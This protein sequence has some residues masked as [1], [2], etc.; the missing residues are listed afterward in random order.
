MKKGEHISAF[1][2]P[3]SV[4]SC[5]AGVG[6]ADVHNRDPRDMPLVSGGAKV[7]VVGNGVLACAE[8]KGMNVVFCQLAPWQFDGPKPT[9]ANLRRTH[10][11]V[12]FLLSR[13]LA[14]LGVSG[15]TP[16]LTRF[17]TPVAAARA[18]KRWL[19]GLYLDTPEEW[20]EPYRFFRW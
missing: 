2:E 16:I 10:R 19:D 1:F 8:G 13:L 17:S 7:R 5:L 11:R 6:P 18:E 20:D 14:N 4:E 9:Q 12:S 15:S 3:W